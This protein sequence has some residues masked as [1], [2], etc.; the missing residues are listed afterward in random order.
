MKVILKVI[1]SR[2]IVLG[3]VFSYFLEKDDSL[4]GGMRMPFNK[5]WVAYFFF[6]GKLDKLKKKIKCTTKLSRYRLIYSLPE[7]PCHFWW[8]IYPLF[9]L[10]ISREIRPSVSS[11]N[12]LVASTLSQYSLTAGRNVP[13]WWEL[14]RSKPP[15]GHVAPRLAL[16]RF[17]RWHSFFNGMLKTAPMNHLLYCSLS[18]VCQFR[19]S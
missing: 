2:D 18:N 5:N 7:N 3:P 1:L 19:I 10:W 13:P 4:G 14:M 15:S 12:P 9:R 17:F 16:S 8:Q 6:P 11:L